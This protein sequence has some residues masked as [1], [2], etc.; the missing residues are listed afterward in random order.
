MSKKKSSQHWISVDRAKYDPGTPVSEHGV[1]FHVFISPY[2]MPEAVRGDFD[3]SKRRFVIEFKY[4][5][6]EPLEHQTP[7][8][9]VTFVVGENSRRLYR[10][11][12]DV[13]GMGADAVVLRVS[14]AMD[15]LERRL[16]TAHVPADNFTV[17]RKVLT[18][19]AGTF[20]RTFERAR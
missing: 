5:A 18:D 16:G 4:I 17:A 19:N 6:T 13:E 8:D 11:E 1:E 3:E 7:D 15:A 14:R 20:A 9:Y 10:I 12:V 2:D